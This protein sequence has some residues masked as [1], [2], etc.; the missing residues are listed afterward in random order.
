MQSRE[1]RVSPRKECLV[2]LRFRIVSNG[3]EPSQSVSPG[4]PVR[5][6]PFT[7]TFEGQAVNLSERGIYFTSPERMSIG[8]PLEMYF[9][10]PRELTGR[11]SEQV[12]CSARVVHVEEH[13]DKQGMLGVGAAVDRFEPVSIRD[14]GN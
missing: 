6:L 2:P 10:I 9:T 11:A 7:G 5:K 12:R 14:W 13:A 8:Q 3:S 1:R 4:E